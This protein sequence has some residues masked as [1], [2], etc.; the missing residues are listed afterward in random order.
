MKYYDLDHEVPVLWA[1]LTD[2]YRTLLMVQS[3][4]NAK[5][6]AKHNNVNK[7]CQVC[8]Y[9]LECFNGEIFDGE[10]WVSSEHGYKR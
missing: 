6:I 5:E 9:S 3:E 7:V 10:K 4:V 8:P 2:D 1:V